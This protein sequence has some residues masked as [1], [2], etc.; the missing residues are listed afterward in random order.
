[1]STKQRI[2]YID[3][4]KGF[5]IILVVMV[6][7]AAFY[8]YELPGGDFFKAFRMPLYFF[9]SGCFFKAYGGFTDFTKRKVNKLL[10]PFLFWYILT[11]VGVPHLQYHVFG[12][13]CRV[14]HLDET[15]SAIF[16]E[17]YPNLPIWFLLCLFEDSLLFYGLYMLAQKFEQKSTWIICGGAMLLGIIGLTLG[18]NRID[19]PATL[20]SALSALPF[21]AA[22]YVVFRKTEILKPNRFDRYLP[23]LIIAAFAFVGYFCTFYSFLLNRFTL[24]SALVVYPCGLLG[25]YGVV[26]LAKML[27]KLPVVSYIGRYSIMVL[28]THVEVYNFYAAL[29][30]RTG[31]PTE[32]AVYVN[33]L[34]TLLSYLIII[35]L[36]KRFL[37]HVTAQKDVIPVETTSSNKQA[38]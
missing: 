4:A 6:H 22:G 3:L 37:P 33:L 31:L 35:P 36:M 11:S 5:C 21:F 28:V 29:L 14:L 17:Y 18:I 16:T 34:I 9:L 26:M 24:H 8:S 32:Y 2:E 7:I 10:I 12:C 30:K 15:V 38:K 23:L 25:T 19:L 27:K 20:D 1:M 13:N